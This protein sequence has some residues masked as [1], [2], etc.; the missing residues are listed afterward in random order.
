MAR[1]AKAQLSR[2]RKTTPH[3]YGPHLVAAL[4]GRAASVLIKL[5]TTTAKQEEKL[6]ASGQN[7]SRKQTSTC[8]TPLQSL[9]TT[10]K[11]EIPPLADPLVSFW[12]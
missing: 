7:H 10:E 9:R 4:P 8:K 1:G 5:S 12:R 6:D 2:T 3:K 11:R